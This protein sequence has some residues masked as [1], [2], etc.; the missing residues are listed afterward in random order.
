MIIAGEASGD[1]HG[2]NLIKAVRKIDN[3]IS[4]SGIGGTA[5]KAQGVDLFFN[6]KSLSVMG[7]T[8]VL[9]KLSI[10]YKAL[11]DTKR[12]LRNHRPDLLILVDFPGFNLNIAKTAK[13]QGIPVLYYISPKV[14]AWRSD[15]VK[16]IK[17]FVDHMAIIL[18][19]E[20]EFYRNQHVPV[21]YVGHPLMDTMLSEYVAS[22]G[23]NKGSRK[24]I[25]LLP[26]SRENEITGILPVMMEAAKL[27]SDRQEKLKFVVS[28]APSIDPNLIDKITAPFQ[29]GIHVEMT[30]TGVHEIFKKVD[31]I[32]AASGTVTL[33]A[34]IAGIPMVVLYK[35]SGISYF[36]AQ[37][38]VKVH[39]ASLVNLIAGKEVVPEL[40][41]HEANPKNIAATV[42]GILSNNATYEKM[43]DDLARVKNKL[44]GP[45]ASHRVA[46]IAMGM[47]T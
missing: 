31:F 25:G 23:G 39:H 8:E 6:I 27:L 11:K 26:G 33:E 12:R 29:S 18:P 9:L 42:W 5:M 43:K 3:G 30:T 13:K 4:F 10:V 32:M 45:G 28:M 47:I 14:W 40:L 37:K 16:K 34:A 36:L 20:Q 1:L 7:V 22:G 15:R 24:V 35:M 46:K 38:L 2:S 41:Q 19:F 21:T 17:T 44:G